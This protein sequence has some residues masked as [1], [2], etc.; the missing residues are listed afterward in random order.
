MT[1]QVNGRTILYETEKRE[2]D[3]YDYIESTNN[4][5]GIILEGE[6][7]VIYYY[8]RIDTSVLV[9]HQDREGNPL[10]EDELIEG[11]I[12]D[13]YTTH[14][15][16]I[17]NYRLYSVTD[18]KEGNME[19]DQI[20]VV[21]VYEKIPTKVIVKYVDIETKEEI[22]YQEEEENGS[23][24]EK[25]YGYEINGYIGEEYDTNEEDIPYYEYVE[26]TDNTKGILTENNDTVIYY[27]RKLSFNLK[28]DKRVSQMEIDGNT[29][30]AK[31]EETKDEL[32]KIEIHRKKVEQTN[33][34]I[35]YKIKITNIGEIEGIAG[36]IQE[37]IPDGF[38]YNQEDNQTNWEN[39]QGKL[40]T[41]DLARTTIQPGESIEL[42]IVLQ[43]NKNAE[44][45]GTKQNQVILAQTTNP[46]NYKETNEEDNK[47]QANLIMTVST[48]ENTMIK[49]T[50][51][52]GVMCILI[53][54]GI[55]IGDKVK[56]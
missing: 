55:L 1:N 13:P 40:V 51:L 41:Y 34:K 30:K 3:N 25:T 24:Q 5:T 31:T 6:Q 39:S 49:V 37:I 33:V 35:T 50:I 15:K 38:S 8:T 4:E 18:N 43:W 21:Y 46:A 17:E 16:E 10:A 42:E 27:Y 54:S 23:T 36:E 47:S 28:I 32:S 26:S 45:F 7:E 29:R 53:G 12:W 56:K 19:K 14:E 2:I 20:V 11:K 22:T 52:V 48:G 9:K 44:N